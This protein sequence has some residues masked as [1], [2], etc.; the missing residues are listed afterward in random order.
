MRYRAEEHGLSS[1]IICDSAGTHSYHVGEAP[2]KRSLQIAHNRGI[3]MSDLRA[4]KV[5]MQDFHDFNM[6]L[7]L[8]SEH[9]DILRRLAPANSKAKVDLFLNYAGLGNKDVPDPYYGDAKGFEHVIDLVEHG[10]AGILEKWKQS[11]A[12]Q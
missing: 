1:M 11:D 12:N 7:G 10:V 4:R 5:R 3:P 6:I 8:D 9:V 2:D